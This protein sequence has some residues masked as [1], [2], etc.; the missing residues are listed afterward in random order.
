MGHANYVIA[1]IKFVKEREHAQTFV[2]GN[3]F[4]KPWCSFRDSEEKQRGDLLELVASKLQTEVYLTGLNRAYSF[5]LEDGDNQ[6]TPVFCMYQLSSS[7]RV[8][9][10]NLLLKDDRLKEFG[11]YGVIINSTGKFVER[12]NRNLP[13][14]SYGLIDYIDFGDLRNKSAIFK[15]PI[16]KKDYKTFRHQREFRVYNTHFAIT[17][18]NN[19]DNPT[20]ETIQPNEFGASF[21]S[22]EDISDIAEIHSM[23]E[24]FSGV[25][26]NIQD[27]I[28][29]SKMKKE[30]WWNG[31][32]Y[33][34]V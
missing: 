5:W 24:L 31:K 27:P 23:D 9:S 19:L 22:I 4:C 11:N 32:N 14:F 30:L 3:L 28:S 33:Q 25:E 21:F 20:I 26:I 13:G 34:E 29:K 17:D 7:K 18:N 15:T 1:L 2:N 16:L 12:L 8:A 6:F 10:M